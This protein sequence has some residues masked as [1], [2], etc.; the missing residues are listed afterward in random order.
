MVCNI[1]CCLCDTSPAR[2]HP[3]KNRYRVLEGVCM[4]IHQHALLA[5]CHSLIIT[6]STSSHVHADASDRSTP[7]DECV[8]QDDAFAPEHSGSVEPYPEIPVAQP[9]NDIAVPVGAAAVIAGA[10]A[11]LTFP[12][13]PPCPPTL[14]E[15]GGV[16]LHPPSTPSSTPCG[17]KKTEKN[18]FQ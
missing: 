14:A 8:L 5:P 1:A 6:Q 7:P 2:G 18:R 15:V 4:H 3:N 11:A 10:A 13:P 12:P 9:P 17:A 16:F